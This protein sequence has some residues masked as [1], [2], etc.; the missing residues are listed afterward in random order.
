MKTGDGGEGVRTGVH[1]TEI[2]LKRDGAHHR[3]HHHRAAG[4]D[5]V[6]VVNGGVECRGRDPHAFDRNAIA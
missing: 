1:G 3:A 5:I 4:V 2:F 6:A